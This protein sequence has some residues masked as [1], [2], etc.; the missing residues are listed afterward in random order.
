MWR[1]ER[2]WEGWRLRGLDL[3]GNEA[4]LEAKMMSKELGHGR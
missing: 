3:L 2:V 1:R 4:L